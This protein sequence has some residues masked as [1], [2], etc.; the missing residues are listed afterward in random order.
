MV[1]VRVA[2][3]TC[4]EIKLNVHASH[5][6]TGIAATGAAADRAS[7]GILLEVPRLTSR[8][9]MTPVLSFCLLVLFNLEI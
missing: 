3:S 5:V 1:W 6:G 4:S 7:S 8:R 9:Q 2:E